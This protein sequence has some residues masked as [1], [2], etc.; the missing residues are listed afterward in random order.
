MLFIHRSLSALKEGKDFPH[1]KDEEDWGRGKL[2]FTLKKMSTGFGAQLETPL[3]NF[4]DFS[5]CLQ[6][7]WRSSEVVGA[8]HL[9]TLSLGCCQFR[10]LK[11]GGTKN[12]WMLGNLVLNYLFK[13]H[14]DHFPQIPLCSLTPHESLITTQ[15]CVYKCLWDKFCLCSHPCS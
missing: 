14:W 11:K 10:A 2:R 6:L 1:F 12:E 4:S 7:P 9:W 8:Q 3:A 15:A 5:E 13:E